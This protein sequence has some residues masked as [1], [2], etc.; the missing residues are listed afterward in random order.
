[1]L[2]WLAVAMQIGCRVAA[3]GLAADM[4][5]TTSVLR[6]PARRAT[7]RGRQR[8]L[9]DGPA[10]DAC[11]IAWPCSGAPTG[12]TIRF[13]TIDF[14]ELPEHFDAY[15]KGMVRGRMVVRIGA[16]THP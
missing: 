12:G 6:H 7:P 15:L 2:A 4:K 8:Q 13:R 10:P 14:E 1:M 9:P 16:D 11:G 5:L 3:V